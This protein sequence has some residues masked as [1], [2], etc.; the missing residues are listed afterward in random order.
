MLDPRGRI[1]CQES[2]KALPSDLFTESDM[3]TFR[4]FA[5]RRGIDPELGHDSEL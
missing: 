1:K 2:Q 5:R 3:E 4:A